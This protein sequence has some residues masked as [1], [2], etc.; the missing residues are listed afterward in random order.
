MKLSIVIPM[1]NESAVIAQTIAALRALCDKL[2]YACEIVF[3][4][5]GSTD[6]CT[7]TV[8]AAAQADSRILLV[9]DELN[10]GKGAAVRSGM[11]TAAGDI[12]VFTD[13]DLAYGTEQIAGIVAHHLKAGRAVTLGSRSLH[14]NGY[15]GYSIPRQAMS[16]LY[17]A[18]LRFSAGFSYSDSQTGLKCFSAEAAHRIFSCCCTDGFAFDLEALMIAEKLGYTVSEFPVEVLPDA[19]QRASRVRPVRDAYLMLQDIKKIKRRLQTLEC[20]TDQRI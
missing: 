6:G 5:D 10:K 20:P 15:S 9:R 3:S 8:A 18:V 19:S 12:A 1:Y 17:R 4:D 13:C 14:K 11:L 16:R 2:P 7:N